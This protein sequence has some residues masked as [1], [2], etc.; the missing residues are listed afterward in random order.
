MITNLEKNNKPFSFL[1]YMP[2]FINYENEEEDF[3]KEGESVAISDKILDSFNKI[4][5][6]CNEK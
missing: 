6:F 1:G 4:Y 3:Y 5:E 2:Y